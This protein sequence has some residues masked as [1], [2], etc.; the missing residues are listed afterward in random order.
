MALGDR[1]CLGLD[2]PKDAAE[3]ACWYGLAAD[4]GDGTA[5]HKF[6]YM[7]LKGEGV[8]QDYVQAYKWLNLAAA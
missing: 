2:G 4:R 8:P 7:Y 1:Y 5:R 3:A 6:G